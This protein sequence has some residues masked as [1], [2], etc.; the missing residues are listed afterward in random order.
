MVSG[1]QRVRVTCEGEGG[2]GSH[3]RLHEVAEQHVGA[4]RVRA[5][6]PLVGR[7]RA[8]RDGGA[9]AAADGAEAAVGVQGG[10][11]ASW[12]GFGRPA[13]RGCFGAAP[14]AILARGCERGGTVYHRRRARGVE[15]AE[16]RG[17]A[18]L[19]LDQ[20]EREEDAVVVAV[21]AQLLLR[22]D[23]K[24]PCTRG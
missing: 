22:R 9:D 4:R 19:H 21:D 11:K 8:E 18:V 14:Q 3:A 16:Q 1:A 2:S 23:S 10:K 5:L 24:P 13:A 6:A 17:R 7:A 12:F 20:D 15:R